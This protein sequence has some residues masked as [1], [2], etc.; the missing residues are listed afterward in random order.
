MKAREASL[1]ENRCVATKQLR[2]TAKKERHGIF[3]VYRTFRRSLQ[4]RDSFL[5]YTVQK[6]DTWKKASYEPLSPGRKQRRL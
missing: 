2:R 4:K 5:V 6:W 1:R 3:T